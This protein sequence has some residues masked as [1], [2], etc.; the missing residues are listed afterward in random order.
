MTRTRRQFAWLV[1]AVLTSWTATVRPAHA[2]L[3]E[4]LSGAKVEGTVTKID[5]A[6]KEVR[7]TRDVG[8]RAY[9]RTYPYDKI[10]AVTMGGKRHVLTEKSPTEPSATPAKP[11]SGALAKSSGSTP[12][13]SGSGTDNRRSRTEVLALIEERGSTPP[14]WFEATPLNYP[15]SLDLAWP[16]R[17]EGKD[18]NNQ[19]NVGQYVWDIINTNPSKWKEGVRF[20]HHLR[21]VHK[22]HLDV[23]TRAEVELG[24]MYHGLLQDDARGA[25]W[26]QKV[27]V[28]EGTKFTRHG[29]ALATCYYRLGN[30]QMATELLLKLEKT[31]PQLGL[32]K[33]WGDLGDLRKATQLAEAYARGSPD[34]APSLFVLAADACR[35]NGRYAQALQYYQKAV[36]APV[37]GQQAKRAERE[38]NRARASLEAI[39]LFELADVRRVPDGTYEA[40]SLGYETQLHVA[41]TVKAGKIES[42]RVTQHKEK[43]FYTSLTETPAQIVQKQGIQGVD[44]VSGATITSEAIINATA[45]ALAGGAKGAAK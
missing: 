45:K 2:D 8:G 42:V 27:G 6:A 1:I 23:R 16:E 28:Q 20:M 39:Q 32:I 4:L 7:L 11:G 25:Y 38:Q 30:K 41:V 12:K 31:A 34:L 9:E 14:E 15:Q 43:Q 5:K 24:R 3:I 33:T 22:D 17:P 35:T 44:A 18:W 40:S 29:P 19:K 13:S 37:K 36:D 21:S 26:W 10:H